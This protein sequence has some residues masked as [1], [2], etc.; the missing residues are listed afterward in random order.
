M[1]SLRHRLHA[2]FCGSKDNPRDLDLGYS[3]DGRLLATACGSAAYLWDTRTW[4]RTARI[5][6][7]QPTQQLAFSPD[8]RLLAT[9][10]NRGYVSVYAVDGGARVARFPV[11]TVAWDLSFSGDGRYLVAAS[12][13]LT[14]KGRA[15]V[16]DLREGRS[17][18]TIEHGGTVHAAAFSPDSRLVL[19]GSADGIAKLTEAASGALQATLRHAGNVYAV[20]FS[21]DGAH[22]MTGGADGSVRVWR[23]ADGEPVREILHSDP[24]TSISLSPDGRYLA[25]GGHDNQVHVGAWQT[26]ASSR[27]SSTLDPSRA[28]RSIPATVVTRLPWGTTTTTPAASGCGATKTCARKPVRASPA[29]CRKQNAR[30]TCRR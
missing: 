29:R 25:T 10:G 28:S 11:D 17:L 1:V 24:V 22:A 4:A 12:G 2:A 14:G 7:G 19:T 20:A 8:G 9:G 18:H 21:T 13:G 30:A 6:D 3:P 26:D 23:V 15:I 16:W 27:A 5:A